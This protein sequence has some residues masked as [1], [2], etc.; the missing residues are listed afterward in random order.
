MREGLTF[1][2]AC[3]RVA[4]AEGVVW[5][6]VQKWCRANNVLSAHPNGIRVRG[7]QG[8]LKTKYEANLR[9]RLAK[10]RQATEEQERRDLGW[11]IGF[12][13]ANGHGGPSWTTTKKEER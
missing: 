1:T 11:A 3:K 2:D 13:F 9:A 8:R 5:V 4:E 10:E 12:A 7:P 6:A